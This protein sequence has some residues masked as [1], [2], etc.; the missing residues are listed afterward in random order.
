MIQVVALAHDKGN[1]VALGRR[2]RE[3]GLEG[4]VPHL[5]L[6]VVTGWATDDQHMVAL[7]FVD[8]VAA[9]ERGFAAGFRAFKP[10]VILLQEE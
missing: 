4:A 1:V 10:R 5:D 7:A 3:A 9:V 8:G 6:G 2:L